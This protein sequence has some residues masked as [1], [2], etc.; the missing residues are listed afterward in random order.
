MRPGASVMDFSDGLQ[1]WSDAGGTHVTLH[2]EGEG[3]ILLEELADQTHGVR[4]WSLGPPTS[5]DVD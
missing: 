5:L 2:L 4:G 1:R 3:K